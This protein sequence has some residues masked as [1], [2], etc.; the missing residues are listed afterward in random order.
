VER[1][2]AATILI[3]VVAVIVTLALFFLRRAK[4][5][6]LRVLLALVAGFVTDFAIRAGFHFGKDALWS[7][8]TAP[9]ALVYV[10]DSLEWVYRDV[11]GLTTFIARLFAPGYIPEADLILPEDERAYFVASLFQNIVWTFL[12]ATGYFFLS[13][14]TTQRI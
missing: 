8:D 4:A 2:L 12:F 13:R 9:K 6:V 3:S 14:R 7:S 1:F 10:F 5:T 11:C